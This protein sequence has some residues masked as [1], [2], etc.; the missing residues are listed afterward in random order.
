MSEFKMKD[1]FPQAFLSEINPS[2]EVM[3]ADFVCYG[4]EC[5]TTADQDSAI[6]HAVL[7]HDR[8]VKENQRLTAMATKHA[9]RADD[10]WEALECICSYLS[11]DGLI[12]TGLAKEIVNAQRV[13]D[14]SRTEAEQDDA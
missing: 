13:L 1:Y 14:K 7:N 11:E 2:F 12:T 3:D 4:D 9:T 5:N 10:L 6:Q 8:L